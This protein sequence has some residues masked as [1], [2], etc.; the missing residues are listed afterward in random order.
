MSEVNISETK[1]RPK[2]A[3]ISHGLPPS[4]GGQVMVLYRL[5][6]PPVPFDYCL[7]SNAR[8]EEGDLQGGYTGRLPCKY[9]HLPVRWQIKGLN[10]PG[11]RRLRD[12]INLALAIAVRARTIAKIIRSEGCNAVMACTGEITLIP[13]AY[14]ASRFTGAKFYLYIF[15]H[16]SE[17]E[18]Q[19]PAFKYW[20]KKS[21]PLLMRKANCVIVDNN[22]LDEDAKERFGVSGTVIHNAC[23]LSRYRIEEDNLSNSLLERSPNIVFT[24][25]IYVAQLDSVRRIL[26]ALERIDSP[27]V[28]LHL[29][30]A[31]PVELLKEQ[32]ISGRVKYHKH[33]PL[34]EMPQIQQSADILFLPLAFESPYPR[35]IQTSATT[36]M[37]EYLAARRPILVHAPRGSFVAE[38]FKRHEC[39]LVVDEPD[40]DKLAQAISRILGD[41]ELRNRLA[42]RAGERA[43][44]DFDLAL[45]RSQFAGLLCEGVKTDS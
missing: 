43:I 16:Y 11:L 1:G 19:N 17:R 39:G 45:A 44:A 21:E 33:L 34:N 35:L 38:Y 6:A 14:L 29:Y 28:L 13:A 20:A 12:S 2:V 31:Q 8:Y 32:G 40:P 26:E 37:G 23:D 22:L 18:W 41:P 10:V 24:G 36:K 7:L 15:D 3:I 30:T 25:A 27:E 42:A 9:F 4:E 5:L